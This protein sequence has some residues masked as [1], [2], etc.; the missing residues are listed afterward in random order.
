[1][2]GS[3][4]YPLITMQAESVHVD[5][6]ALSQHDRE[7][8]ADLLDALELS[9]PS[10]GDQQRTVT[11]FAIA[12]EVSPQHPVV[13]QL[14]AGLTNL[15]ENF[16][17]C[18][19]F[20]YGDNTLYDYLQ[21]LD[22][23][24]PPAATTGRR[25]VMAFGLEQVR[26]ADFARFGREMKQLNLGREEIFKRNL[27]LIF[28]LNRTDFLDYF[29]QQAPDFWDWRG[30][31]ARFET[32]PPLEPLFYPYLEWLITENSRLKIGGVMQVQRQVD[33]FLD[34]I[35]VSL[36]AERVEERSSVSVERVIATKIQRPSRSTRSS[37]KELD[38]SGDAETDV[39]D[40]MPNSIVTT[41]REEVSSTRRVEKLD[42]AEA[43]RKSN[44]CVILGDPGAGKTTLL[45][46]LA[47]HFALAK[48]DG[49]ATVKGGEQQEDLG[50]SRLPILF[51]IADYAE[52][53][54][55]CPDL[56]LVDYLRQFYRQ[57]EQYFEESPGDGFVSLLLDKMAAGECLILLD[58]LDE[59]FDE[60]SRLQVVQ[61]IDRFV[62]DYASN[63]F[64]V[65]S[66]IAGYREAA[67]GN[68][69]KEFTIAPMDTPQMEQFLKRWCLAIEVA[70]RPEVNDTVRQRDAQRE[71]EGILQDIDR[72]PGVKR[73]ATNPLLLTILALI[74]RN[75][76]R[77]PQ[78]RIDLYQLAT[79]TLIED[80]Q[81]GR[82]LFYAPKT[83]QLQLTEEEVVALL[84]P[85]AFWMHE[86]KPTG[87]ASQVD[88]E[89]HLTPKMAELQGVEPAAALELVRQFLRK[90]RE[91]TGLFVERA[92]GGYGF[93]HLTFEEYF[94]ARHI[95]DNEVSEILEIINTHR[96]ESRW[97]EPILLALG[98]LSSDANRVNRLVG[99]LFKHLEHYQPTLK[100]KEIRLKNAESNAPVLVW[101]SAEAS[102]NAPLQ[103]S[104]AIWKDLLFAGQLLSEVK[105]TSNFRKQL[106]KQLV[107]TYLG[108]EA[109]FEEKPTQQLLRLLRGIE[110]FNQ[111][112]EV[113]EE[114]QRAANQD[115]LSEEQRNNALAAILY[116]A[117]DEAGEGLIER[118]SAIATQL[119][120]P[121]FNTIRSLVSDLGADMTTALKR[122]QEDYKPEPT[123]QIALEFV[124]ALSLIRTDHYDQAIAL[125]QQLDYPSSNPL[126][127][128][129]DWAIAIS[130]EQKDEYV[131]AIEYY[132]KCSNKLN[133]H[134]Q[135]ESWFFLWRNWGVCYRSDEQYERSL[136]Y[137]QKAVQIAQTQ[138]CGKSKAN[139]LYNIGRSYQEWR[140]YEEAVKYYE[141]SRDQY[142][143]LEKESNVA[144]LWYW[145]ADCYRDWGKYEQAVVVE[146]QALVIR[147][148][149]KQP[150][151]VASAYYQLGRIYQAWGKYEEAIAHYEHSRDRYAQLDKET[152]VANL[153]FWIAD[154]YRDWGKYEQALEAEHQELTI[155]EKLQEQ[156]R[157]ALAYFRLGRIYQA[158]GKYEE[159][160][161]HYEHSRDRYAQLDKETSVANQW[162]W[163]ADCS[164]AW[165]KYEDAIAAEQ[166]NLAIR[167]K[168]QDQTNIAGAYFLFGRIY[169]AWGKYEEAIAQYKKSRDRSTQLGKE[170]DVANQWYFMADCYREWGK[171]EQ[172]I[173][174]AQQDLAIREKLLDQSGVASAYFQLGRIYQAWSRYREA[175]AHY[176]QS[177][178]RFTQ[179]GEEASI[180][181]QWYYMADCYKDWGQYEQAIE[182]Q[183]K[184]FEIRQ[185][186]GDKSWVAVSYLQFGQIYQAWGKYEEAIAYHEQSRDR[187]AHLDR[188]SNVGNQWHRIAVCYCDW[189]KYEQSI[190]AEQQELAIREKLQDQ[191]SVADSYYQLGRIYQAWGKYEEAIAHYE[192]S[193]DL[194][195]QLEKE[196]NVANQWSW[197]ADCYRDWGKYEQA[198]KAEHQELVI[199]E[200]LQ[201]QSRIT[202]AYFRLGRIYQA[203]SKYEE[204]IAQYEKSRDLYTQ[205]EKETNIAALFYWLADC[206]REWGKYEQALEAE[207]QELAI[208]EKLQ[209]QPNITDVYYQLGRI[210]QAWGKY[211]EAI[212]QYKKSR[213]IYTQLEK[214]TDVADLWYWISVCYRDWNKYEEAIGAEQH[215]L[216][217]REKLQDQKNIAD[218]YYQM[219]QIYQAWG[220]HEEAI[221]HYKES[222]DRYQELELSED[223]A[224][225]H[226]RLANTRRLLAKQQANASTG[227]EL[228][229]QAE[230]DLQHAIQLNQQGDY[231]GNL[232]YDHIVLSLLLA[233][234]LRYSS[235]DET[236]IQTQIARFEETYRTGFD[237][238][239]Q[240]GQAVNQANKALDI[241][242]AYLEVP[243][244]MQLD[245]AEELAGQSLQV[246]Q[247][248][249]RRKLEADA[250]KLLGEIYLSRAQQ[251]QPG[252]AAM[253]LQYLTESQQIYQEL[254]LGEKA[255]EVAH[256]REN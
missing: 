130:Y 111:K 131:K 54:D 235:G 28:W 256:L 116:V 79:R 57:W 18:P 68:R 192:H 76:V 107:L 217:I 119:T 7:Q 222:R 46:Y 143:L 52:Q 229:N 97:T 29:R 175:I 48:R 35:Y 142:V 31:I 108:M 71:A 134:T 159:A 214:E 186:F 62:G 5:H 101:Q 126:S 206:Y 156:S 44:H 245:R 228:L 204:A 181:G 43:I 137:F 166:Q 69:F 197:I 219:G 64:V 240:L 103:E 163:I 203:W 198:L 180:A 114:L 3:K 11:V 236:A 232:A 1:M 22:H 72:Q 110:S 123:I 208:R 80:W 205:L 227:L 185:T 96:D 2:A 200:K 164:R 32:Q 4:Q 55:Q 58:G 132:Q 92:P 246:F 74:H 165:G 37:L 141:H 112:G 158:W 129:I 188:E 21:T 161:A 122:T 168:L 212:A 209:D 105:I 99:Q 33:I 182:C 12:P 94:V 77:L 73:F 59:V 249:N 98:Y 251:G 6:E 61:Q 67:L 252:A 26:R 253:G 231:Q 70:Q 65:T 100:G 202:L 226:R 124:T 15:E 14:E 139:I 106:V 127:I 178:D 133:I 220:K 254:D 95:A 189:G 225:Q 172:A 88:I 75:G 247:A 216:A 39:F 190:A 176:E 93:M 34:Q 84:A 91:T 86:E 211:E 8:L 20:Y 118:V 213:D 194:Y 167:E 193:R 113:F 47:R 199:C 162:S 174:A 78:R 248:F 41:S 183:Q 140:K 60:A 25:V 149:L 63:K 51:R 151:K 102:E 170:I 196:T 223:T 23:Q 109:D 104:P 24:A 187:Y 169:Q 50:E 179:I 234:R 138:N 53:L 82:N 87:T 85:L 221:T 42:L 218:A 238:F 241:G 13:K 19:P 177:C 16:Q 255:K 171:F 233:E 17:F 135:P 115:D 243:A 184:C 121:L 40:L 38:A 195:T 136:I 120:P 56:S 152:D 81:L 144:N 224:R 49:S 90:V 27:V 154:C 125:L 147:E 250:R 117:C 160:I 145:L 215:D 157:I 230:Q 237:I 89:I 153:W 45:R 210:Y 242:R 9:E 191:S 66:R 207:H 239:A 10:Q 244:L 150:S 173:V 148:K 201:D 128:Y 36:Q 30:T 155:R 83:T 146:H